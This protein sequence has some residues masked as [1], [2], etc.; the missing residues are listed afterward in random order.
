MNRMKRIDA[1]T[2]LVNADI[3]P[4]PLYALAERLHYDGLTVHSLQCKG[5]L[6]QNLACALCKI[7][8]PGH[9]YAFGGLDY[10]TGRDFLTQAR[11]L[12]EI[13]FDGIK[14]LEGKPTT[15]AQLGM[16]LDDPAYDTYYAYLEETGYPVL[17][18]VADPRTF[19]DKEQV[20]AW[21]LA[22]GWFYDEND[23]P[24]EQYYEEVE[25]M[26]AKHPRLRAIFAHFFF[27]S[28]APERAQKFLDDHPQ[29]FIDITAGIEMYEDF[30]KD[31]PYWRSFFMKN[32][33]RIIFG[34]DSTDEPTDSGDGAVSLNG[35][36][37][38]EIDFLTQTRDIKIYDYALRGLGLPDDTLVSILSE[39]FL[40]LVG[41]M[42]R[43]IDVDALKKEAAWI[44]G[45][46]DKTLHK[47]KL[48]TAVARVLAL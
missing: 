2:H 13:G 44:H 46:L 37:G 8:H 33:R 5:D 25:N 10:L 42:P 22:N 11:H 18:H 9:T 36:A 19:W 7:T 6:S 29:V 35:Y 34:T 48:N 27:L 32:S 16:P 39:N 23:V 12:Q 24:Y 28:W 20:P 26:L 31:T 17:F 21:A 15:R 41:D 3:D 30:S 43:P 47:E 14:M 4:A 45:F 40:S 1:H 38:A